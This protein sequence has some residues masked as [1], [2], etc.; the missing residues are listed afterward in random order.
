RGRILI[1]AN[2]TPEGGATIAV[3]DT[4]PGM[5]PDEIRVALK[6]FGQVRADHLHSHS[7]TGLGLPIAVA[8][9]KQH[10]G[11]LAVASE[12]GAGTTVVLK[13]PP[14]KVDALPPSPLVPPKS[15]ASLLEKA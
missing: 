8:L 9:A 6:P 4:G 1:V 7:G 3:A 11:D 15:P 10:G 14:S 5:T 13:L 2:R 12:P